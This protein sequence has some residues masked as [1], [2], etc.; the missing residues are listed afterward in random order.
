VF[1]VEQAIIGDRHAMGVA[2]DVVEDL[3]RTGQG[4]LRVNDLFGLPQPG[5]GV[6]PGGSIP[7]W[8]ERSLEAECLGVVCG[9]EILQE[10]APEQTRE[11]SH[12]QEKAGATVYNFLFRATAETLASSPLIPRIS[13]PSWDS[14]RSWAVDSDMPTC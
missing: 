8:R 4:P 10:E 2:P 6:R 12:G 11:H 3:L 5:E 1:D 14:L 13:G 9:L 7:E